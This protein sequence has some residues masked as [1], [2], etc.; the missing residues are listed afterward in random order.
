MKEYQ[1]WKT[2]VNW[3]EDSGGRILCACPPGGSVYGYNKCCFIN[4]LTGKRDEPDIMFLLKNTLYIIE[5][6]PSYAGLI[7]N[8]INKLNNESDVEK[9]LRI[10][11]NYLCHSYN[12]QLISNYGIKPELIEF[13]IG[14]GY[15]KSR[16]EPPLIDT[17][18]THFVINGNNVEVKH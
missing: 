11:N 9:L 7:A 13:K 1:V 18:L 16:K 8:N 10:K 3:I 2:I 4:P 15:A 5:C 6:K 12:Q 17:R 14:L